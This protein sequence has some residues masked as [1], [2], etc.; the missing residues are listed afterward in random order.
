MRS[1]I[2]TVANGGYAMFKRSM[3]VLP[4]VAVLAA[5]AFATAASAA[6]SRDPSREDLQEMLLTAQDLPQATGKAWMAGA[7]VT[8]GPTGPAGTTEPS[9]CPAMDNAVLAQNTGL[10]DSGVQAF[11]TSTGEFLEQTVVYDPAANQHVTELSGA[12]KECPTMK[13]SDGPAVTL[14]PVDFGPAVAGFH[15]VV[16]GESQSAVL[17][18]SHRDYVVELVVGDPSLTDEQLNSLLQAAFQEIDNPI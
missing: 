4:V 1:E 14:D 5:T 8:T 2:E 13:F 9:G 3:M 16:G 7:L 17:V 15:A 12:I 18:A 11:Y 10:T 6:A